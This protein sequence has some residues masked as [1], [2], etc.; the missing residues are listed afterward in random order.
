[1]NIGTLKAEPA[2]GRRDLLA[3]SVA[4]ALNVWDNGVAAADVVVA[5]IDPDLADTRAFCEKYDVCLDQSA[6]C[7]ILAARREGRAWNTRHTS[8]A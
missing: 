6:N 1:M 3:A 8:F 4:A 7:V 2:L 5:E